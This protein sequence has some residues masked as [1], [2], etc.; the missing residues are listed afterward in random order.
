[1]QASESIILI[2][3]NSSLYKYGGDLAAGAMAA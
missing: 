2:C 1:M 3:F